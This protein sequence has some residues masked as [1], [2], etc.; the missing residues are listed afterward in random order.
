MSCVPPGTVDAHVVERQR[1]GFVKI[2]ERVVIS[3]A[4]WRPTL[5][6]SRNSTDIYDDGLP[7]RQAGEIRIIHAGKVSAGNIEYLHI[8][9]TRAGECDT[10]VLDSRIAIGR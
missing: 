7:C 9:C 4:V 3:K 8:G 10:A 6:A 1:A 5:E 2:E